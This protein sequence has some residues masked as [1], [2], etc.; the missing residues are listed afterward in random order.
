MLPLARCLALVLSSLL[1]TSASRHSTSVVSRQIL[2]GQPPG[3]CYGVNVLHALRGGALDDGMGDDAESAERMDV[4]DAVQASDDDMGDDAESAENMDVVDAV[5]RAEGAA[6]EAIAAA[7]AALTAYQRI[8]TRANGSAL[9]S[10]F[11]PKP[12]PSAQ[13]V[14]QKAMMAAEELGG[15]VAEVTERASALINNLATVP[16]GRPLDLATEVE[17]VVALAGKSS[18]EILAMSGGQ[19][20]AHVAQCDR[21]E[22]ITESSV[23]D[24][25][26]RAGCPVEEVDTKEKQLGWLFSCLR[27]TETTG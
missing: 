17:R 12:K 23:L 26:R 21:D 24:L 7:D 4:V 20:A 11:R 6:N 5:Q 19:V 27:N 3:V 22:R 13:E 9:A 25:A 18:A 1:C 8:A 16:V 2:D 10:W 15:M 14:L